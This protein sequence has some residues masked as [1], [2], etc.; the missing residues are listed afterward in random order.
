[1]NIQIIQVPYD[2]GFRNVRTGK[3]PVHFIQNGIDAILQNSG[4]GVN[5]ST[6]KSN[7][8]FST[9]IG[10]TFD[11]NRALAKLVLSAVHNDR[12]PV[13]LA[14]NCN[15]CIGTIA[16]LESK[17]L[18]VIWFDAHGDFNTP[19]TTTTGFLDGMGLAMAAGRC[20]K[21]LMNTIPGFN[22]VPENCIIHVGSRDLDPEER[23]MFIEAKIPILVADPAD[24]NEILVGLKNALFN[25]KNRV[26]GIYLHVD[27]DV[28]ETE[29]GKPNHLAVPGGLTPQI[30][31]DAIAIIKKHFKI[32]GCAVASYDPAFDENDCVLNAGIGI[33]KAVVSEGI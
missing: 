19:E 5:V 10:T 23:R 32:E 26:D 24:E 33:I 21:P 3:G 12:F 9:E 25:L 14:G 27:M 29:Q 1:M 31:Q 11:V 17:R 4:H 22:P 13:V 28:L 16:G 20:W 2:S 8:S 15:S 6:V 30:V 7:L 18:G